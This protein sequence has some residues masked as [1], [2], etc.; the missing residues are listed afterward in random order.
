MTD[1]DLLLYHCDPEIASHYQT[2]SMPVV[3]NPW[4]ATETTHSLG[5]AM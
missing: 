5:K 4:P 3:D 2:M 1:E